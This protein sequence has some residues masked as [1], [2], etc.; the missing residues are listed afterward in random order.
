MIIFFCQNFGPSGLKLFVRHDVVTLGTKYQYN[1]YYS[2]SRATPENLFNDN[3]SSVPFAENLDVKPQ[4]RIIVR[5][6]FLQFG[7]NDKK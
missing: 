5:H 3:L 6:N 2:Q 1:K 7:R 4:K